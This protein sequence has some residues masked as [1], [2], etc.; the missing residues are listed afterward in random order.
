MTAVAATTH[1]PAEPLAHYRDD[2]PPARALGA[3]LGRALPV[4]AIVL[5]VAGLLPLLVAIV[6]TGDTASDALAAA[7]VG[8]AVL[9]GGAAAGRP[10]RGRLR[11]TVPPAVRL[12]EYAGLLW[13]A[14]LDGDA[15]TRTAFALLAVLAF[16]HYDLVYRLRFQGTTPPR[17]LGDAALGWEGRLLAVWL[18][19]ALDLLPGALWVAA[20]LLAVAF[21]ADSALGWAR[22][23]RDTRPLHFDDEEDEAA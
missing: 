13:L 11:W 5:V 7:I 14:A 15:A 21:A 10:L 12:T 20:G 19:L 1:A 16:R 18:L 2:G 23:S 6:V 3:T 17:W 22:A 4:S 8:W 9:A